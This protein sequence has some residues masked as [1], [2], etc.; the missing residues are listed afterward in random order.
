MKGK[1]VVVTGMGCVTPLGLDV[2]ANWQALMSGKSGIELIKSFDT[3]N[4]SVRI[5][6]ELK[7]FDLAHWLK[8]KQLKRVDTFIVYGVAAAQEALNM[9]SQGDVHSM[10]SDVDLERF[11]VC[12]G[13]GIGGL[14]S[15]E[16]NNRKYF[17]SESGKISPFYVPGVIINMLSGMLS[18]RFGLKG[19]N[20]S[21]VSACTTGTHAL[22]WASRMI[23]Y[24]EAD[25]MLAGGSEKACTP[26]GIAGFAAAR[27]LSRRGDEPA[28]ASRPWDVDRDGFVLSD[29]SG[30]V[31]LESLEHAEKRGAKILAE[32]VGVGYSSDAY[33]MTSPPED[34]DGA[35]RCMQNALE[36]ADI[37]CDQIGYINAHGTSTPTGDVAEVKAVKRLMEKHIDSLLMSSTKSM[38]G[39]ML[40]AA[41]AVE[42]IYT[43]LALMNQ[44]APPTI[45][46]DN[47]DPSCDIDLVAHFAKRFEAKYALSNSFGFGGTNGT[48]IFKSWN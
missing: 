3:T 21:P 40:G 37:S 1:R 33:H 5:G 13:S 25:V 17:S 8:N 28:K 20:V 24:G 39:H 41:G 23:A 47:P 19:P 15:I 9:A 31:V 34:G 16:D 7:N 48:L 29:G 30:M 22:S 14:S 4:S 27:A 11:G 32:I 35:W 44:M 12:A 36:D 42:S 2:D 6:G 18:M 38:S 26:T 46:L 45:N 43:I 10:L